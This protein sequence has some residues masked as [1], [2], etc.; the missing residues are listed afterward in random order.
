MTVHAAILK[1][2][3]FWKDTSAEMCT[4]GSKENSAVSMPAAMY[5]AIM[6][7]RIS[8]S[9]ISNHDGFGSNH[10]KLPTRQLRTRQKV[11]GTQ[12]VV[13]PQLMIRD[14]CYTLSFYFLVCS[15]SG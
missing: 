9:D 1:S 5:E 6:T 4:L 10:E 3:V 12:R 15:F 2:A 7:G 13:L 14:N 8:P 11:A